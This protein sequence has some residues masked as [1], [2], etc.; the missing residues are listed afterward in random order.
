LTLP[1]TGCIF[2][3]VKKANSYQAKKQIPIKQEKANSYQVKQKSKFL[4]SKKKQI[5]IKNI[6]SIA[7]NWPYPGGNVYGATKSFVTQFS[8]NLRADLLGTNLRVTNIEPGM[9]ETEFSNV[10][11]KGDDTK[12]DSVYKGT[13]PLIGEDIAD[14]V[15][16][17]IKRPAHVNINSIEVMS[18]DQAWGHLAVHR[19]E[20]N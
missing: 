13:A 20:Q 9:A 5:P 17:V 6:S 16:W 8:R 15:E 12:A 14:C 10:R 4:S 7:G 11:F 3:P 1:C 18:I 19:R 2:H